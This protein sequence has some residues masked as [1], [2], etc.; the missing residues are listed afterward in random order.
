MCYVKYCVYLQS[1]EIK[2]SF[3]LSVSHK[4]CKKTR[5]RLLK[6]GQQTAFKV[7]CFNFDFMYCSNTVIAL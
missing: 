1:L 7:E 5:S 6:A 4:H 3:V 2:K